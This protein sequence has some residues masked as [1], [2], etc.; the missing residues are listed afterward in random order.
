[1]TEQGLAEVP[2]E[3]NE[4]AR[5]PTREAGTEI[6]DA[7]AGQD[8]YTAILTAKNIIRLFFERGLG[9]GRTVGDILSD[10]LELLEELE[11]VVGELAEELEERE[12]S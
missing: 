9:R 5:A 7:E 2:Q 1:M 11:E 10:A 8:L 12:E 6:S 3:R 4:D